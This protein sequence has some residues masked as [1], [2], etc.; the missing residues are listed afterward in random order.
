MADDA[1]VVAGRWL[2]GKLALT[3][4]AKGHRAGTDAALLAAACPNPGEGVIADLG[5]GVG[6]VGLA[7]AWR[8][9]AATALLV[10]RDADVLALAAR[11][12]ADN[13]LDGRVRCLEADLLGGRITGAAQAEVVLTNPPFLD[14]A[15]SRASHERRRSD[16]H[17]LAPADLKLWM[18]AAG[19]MLS[20]K[21]RL[22][23][24]H[25]A[26]A[27]VDLLDALPKGMGDVA[28]LPLLPRDGGEATRVLVGARKGSR[29]PLRLLAPLVLHRA[30]GGFTERADLLHRGEAGLSLW[31]S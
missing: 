5:C 20:A 13:G 1:D 4:F 2:G 16:A 10:D 27:L 18:A 31:P 24:I 12:I 30:E 14:P 29:S 26:D 19:R 9:P 15:R 3:Q 8:W 23:V 11:N 7:A 28:V 21:G 6:S 17:M 25:R 22:V